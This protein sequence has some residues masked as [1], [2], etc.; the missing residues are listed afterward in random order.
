M[1]AFIQHILESIYKCTVPFVLNRGEIMSILN[2]RGLVGDGAEIGVKCGQF[3]EYILSRWRGRLLYSVDPWREFDMTLYHDDDNVSQRE[4]DKNYEITARRLA[5]FGDRT[6]LLRM[7]S[8]EAARTI[9]DASLDFVYLDARHD[10]ESV[11]EDIGLWYPKVRP[12]GVLA[13]H[14]YMNRKEIGGTVFGV[15]QAVDEFVA[16]EKLNVKVTVRE[17]VYKSWMVF[18]P[19]N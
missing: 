17:P 4:H 7:T 8:D 14:D 5:K 19:G 1:I 2:A 12:G 18:K 3:S 10:Y 16:R 6:K 11:K 9:A 13:G 15:K